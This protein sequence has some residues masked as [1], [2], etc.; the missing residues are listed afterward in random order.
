LGESGLDE[1]IDATLWIN[2]FVNHRNY[3]SESER[4]K[5]DKGQAKMLTNINADPESATVFHVNSWKYINKA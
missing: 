5:L 2:A 1:T 4:D 3:I